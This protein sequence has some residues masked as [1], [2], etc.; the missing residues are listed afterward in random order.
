M[1]RTLYPGGQLVVVNLNETAAPCRPQS[2]LLL[3]D[4]GHVH[5][6]T[7]AWGIRSLCAYQIAAADLTVVHVRLAYAG[8][9]LSTFMTAFKHLLASRR[10]IRLIFL[11][12]VLR[13]IV[14]RLMEAFALC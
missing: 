10:A 7:A 3:V 13:R 11:V 1:L 4:R 8:E 12:T 9:E 2:P 6:R 14:N 5:L